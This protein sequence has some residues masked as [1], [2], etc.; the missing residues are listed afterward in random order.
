MG[1]TLRMTLP[2]ELDAEIEAAV[3]CGEYVSAEA[4]VV[5]AVEQWRVGR[6]TDASLDVDALRK[7]WDQGIASGA[8]EDLSIDDI[9]V[10]A[11]QRLVGG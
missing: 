10:R 11:R 9:K 8:G 6:R 1:R 5:D 2:D 3:S 7:L 4:I